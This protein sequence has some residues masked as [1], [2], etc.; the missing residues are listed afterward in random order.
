[1][2]RNIEKGKGREEERRGGEQRAEKTEESTSRVRGVL[3][4]FKK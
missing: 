4:M 1:M 2:R 3:L